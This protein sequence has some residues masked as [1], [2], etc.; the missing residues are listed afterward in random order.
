MKTLTTKTPKITNERRPEA[1]VNDEAK[2]LDAFSAGD[3]AHQG[4]L[5]I[6]GIRCLPTSARL[7]ENRQLAEGHTQ[8][9]RHVLERGAV[10]EADKSE[11]AELIFEATKCRVA[12]GYIGPVFVSPAE[13]TADDLT[14]PEHGNLGFPAEQ[15]CAVVYQRNIVAELREQRLREERE[16]REW[17]QRER[18]Q[19]EWEQRVRD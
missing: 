9:S 10:Y 14:H 4:D 17:E 11:V 15:V 6:V 19:R 3:V 18:E 12:W 8:G 1:I 13:P 2:L 16:Q 5:I 7:R